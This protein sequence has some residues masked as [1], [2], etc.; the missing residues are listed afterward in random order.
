MTN[1]ANEKEKSVRPANYRPM[2]S[3]QKKLEVPERP[4]YYRRWFRGD[5]GRINRALQAGY[6]FVDPSAVALNNFDLGGDAK[7]S[8]NTDLG[9]SRVSVVSGE[10]ADS[11]GQ[12]ER[13][14]LMECPQE[15]YEESKRYV[16]ERNDSVAAALRG[17]FAEGDGDPEGKRYM[18]G[19]SPDL[20]IKKRR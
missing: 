6:T 3:G 18:K 11:N 20:F 2:S 13:L 10:G 12:A 16:D 14:Y 19:K 17:G 9:S 4:G 1:P 7:E 5:A 15:L 8:G